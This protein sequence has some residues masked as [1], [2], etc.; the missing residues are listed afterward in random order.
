MVARHNW[1]LLVDV[2]LP[3]SVHRSWT[4][5]TFPKV[6]MML[7]EMVYLLISRVRGAH[8]LLPVPHIIRDDLSSVS[9]G[10]LY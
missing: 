10:L 5:H 8:R 6:V 2:L 3:L 4:I 1:T 9:I 7:L